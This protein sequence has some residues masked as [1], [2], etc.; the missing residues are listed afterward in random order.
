MKWIA[1]VFVETGSTDLSVAIR[2]VEDALR[3]EGRVFAGNVQEIRP[4]DVKDVLGT[5]PVEVKEGDLWRT[6]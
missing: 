2:E 1:V 6:R 4:I 5:M 3:G